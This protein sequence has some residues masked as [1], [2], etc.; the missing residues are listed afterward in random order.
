MST[1]EKIVFNTFFFKC[2]WY[3]LYLTM[4]QGKAKTLSWYRQIQSLKM[5]LYTTLIEDTL[6][7]RSVMS[8]FSAY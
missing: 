6:A 1:G 4:K 2:N 8:V 5:Y 7:K 3:S